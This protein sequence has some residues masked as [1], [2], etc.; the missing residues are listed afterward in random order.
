MDQRCK[1]DRVL[2]NGNWE[3]YM[4]PHQIEKTPLLDPEVLSFLKRLNLSKLTGTFENEEV[5]TMG[6]L[7]KLNDEDLKE[8]GIKL[9]HRKII[10][11]EISKLKQQSTVKLQEKMTS[12]KSTNSES[13]S[14]AA[15]STI[16]QQPM[17]ASPAVEKK[18]QLLF[19]P[20][21]RQQRVTESPFL[22]IFSSGRAADHCSSMFG[23]YRKTEEMREGRSVYTQLHDTQYKGSPSKLFT[24]K[25]V[26]SIED[27]DGDVNL[28]ATT[29][30]N[31]PT[32]ATW[33]YYDQNKETMQDDPTLTVTS[34]S[35]KPK[36]CEM[37]IRFSNH[38]KSVIDEPGVE[39]LYKSYGSYHHGRP[40]LQHVGGRFTLYAFYGCWRVS[41]YVGGDVYLESGSA[42]SQCPANPRAARS[43][44]LARTHWVYQKE[45][46]D[47]TESSGISF[48]CKTH[49]S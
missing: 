30:S 5:L 45:D 23:L 14:S 8:F 32:S 41:P 27:S 16:K 4:W 19:P 3:D 48:K 17:N 22:L 1:A 21:V 9:V 10:L 18:T 31:S 11:E 43:E 37:T 26:W 35:V 7:F 38:I 20:S 47:W 39:G 2:G 28:M 46:F 29:P 15:P 6:I 40:V 42:P 25:G 44:C 24:D 12:D 13:S 33:Q 49:L 34:L 36:N